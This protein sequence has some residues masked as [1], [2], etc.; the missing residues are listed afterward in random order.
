M[1][2]GLRGFSLSPTGR[3]RLL[4]EPR[5]CRL[6]ILE[7]RAIRFILLPGKEERAYSCVAVCHVGQEPRGHLSHAPFTVVKTEPLQTVNPKRIEL[8]V[9]H[10][11]L[12]MSKP[13]TIFLF[14]LGTGHY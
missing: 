1:D 12:A 4:G 8:V 7:S 10:I 2:G 3:H 9:P 14:I 13:T 11:W 5:L 6:N